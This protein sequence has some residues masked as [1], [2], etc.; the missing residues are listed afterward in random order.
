MRFKKHWL[1]QTIGKTLAYIGTT[2]CQF[3]RTAVVRNGK[4]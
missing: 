3:S 2:D 4:D 1:I